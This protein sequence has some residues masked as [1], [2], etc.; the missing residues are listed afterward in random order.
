MTLIAKKLNAKILNEIEALKKLYAHLYKYGG[1]GYCAFISIR[2][3]ERL[4]T[5]GVQTDLVLGRNVRQNELGD[6]CILAAVEW[7]KQMSPDDPSFY[8][9]IRRSH[10]KRKKPDLTY[11]GYG[12]VAVRSEG[13]IYDP[14]SDQFGLPETYPEEMFGEIWE[15]TFIANRYSLIKDHEFNFKDPVPVDFRTV[16]IQPNILTSDWV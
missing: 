13:I 8:G 4:L 14:T 1:L 9:D 12:H 10:D 6:K 5:K 15:K 7:V 11:R 3:R 16:K 2:L